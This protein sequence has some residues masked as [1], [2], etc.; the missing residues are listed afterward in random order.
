LAVFRGVHAV[1][2]GKVLQNLDREQRQRVLNSPASTETAEILE[3]SD[4]ESVA[5]LT[6]DISAASLSEVLREASADVAADVLRQLPNQRSQEVLQTLPHGEAVAQ[7]LAYPGDTAGGLMTLEYPVMNEGITAGNALDQLRILGTAAENMSAI[8]VVDD[9][10]R[11]VGTLSLIRLALARPSAL[12]GDLTTADLISVST[13]DD[14]EQCAR[15][16]E[17]YNL[18][19]L[20]VVDDGGG[21]TG[22]ILVEDLVDVVNQEATE[23]MYRL[24]AVAGERPFGPLLNSLRTRLPWLYVN[25]ATAFLAALVISIFESTISQVVA[26]AVFLPVVAGQGGVGGTQTLTLVVR[27]IALGDIYGGSGLRMLSRRALIGGDPRRPFRGRGGPGSISLEGEAGLGAGAGD[28]HARQHGCCR[29]GG[30]GGAVAAAAVGDGPGGFVSGFCDDLHRR[31]RVPAVST[32]GGVFHR[33]IDLTVGDLTVGGLAAGDIS[34][35]AN[36]HF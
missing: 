27:G 15:L 24:A 12:V 5:A 29:A 7:L 31:H 33:F 36:L 3:L 19:Q 2:Q 28:R 32:I 11:L 13:A 21:L 1:D 17:R 34:A 9:A 8:P 23:D 26:L 30:R 35:G 25:L 6:R 20:P 10:N 18:N 14:Q 22:V 4:A 16:M